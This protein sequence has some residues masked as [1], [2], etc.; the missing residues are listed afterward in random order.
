MCK[1]GWNR[2]GWNFFVPDFNKLHYPLRSQGDNVFSLEGTT[3]KNTK[4]K[5]NRWLAIHPTASESQQ[6]SKWGGGCLKSCFFCC[7][8]Q[9][10]RRTKRQSQQKSFNKFFFFSFHNKSPFF[11]Y[12]YIFFTTKVGFSLKESLSSTEVLTNKKIMLQTKIIVLNKN[13]ILMLCISWK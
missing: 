13:T 4:Q 1:D 10:R 8:L 2:G 5:K 11:S 3:L 6:K 12:I 9:L 7:V